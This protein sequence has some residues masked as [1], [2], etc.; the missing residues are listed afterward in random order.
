MERGR[1][2]TLLKGGDNERKIETEK[3]R[4][5]EGQHAGQ[6]FYEISVCTDEHT[7]GKKNALPF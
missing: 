5:S 1:T 2:E 3:M 7:V 6:D 4:P